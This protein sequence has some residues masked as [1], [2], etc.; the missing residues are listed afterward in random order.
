MV[1]KGKGRKNGINLVVGAVS[2]QGK[3]KWYRK[4]WVE[5]G[6]EEWNKE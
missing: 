1:R 6:R 2:G 5:K 3:G 4:G